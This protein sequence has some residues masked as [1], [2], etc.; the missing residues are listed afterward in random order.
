MKSKFITTIFIAVL[1]IFMVKFIKILSEALLV[2]ALSTPI[3]FF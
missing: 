2:L 1:I 3:L